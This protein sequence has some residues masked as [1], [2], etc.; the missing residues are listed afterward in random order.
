MS[1]R[2]SVWGSSVLTLERT[3]SSCARPVLDFRR[4]EGR[5]TD[6]AA[7]PTTL[8]KTLLT[9]R[10]MQTH[11]AFCREYDKQAMRIDASLAGTYPSRA[12]FYRWVSGELAGL[13][14]PDHCRVLEALF[15]GHS[16]SEL[17][18]VP[19][20]ERTTEEAVR[21]RAERPVD[22]RP[23][24]ERAFEESRVTID[25]AGFSGETLYG[26]IQEPVD[27]V[28]IGGL[29][30]KEISIRILVPDLS[31][32][33][34][35]PALVSTRGDD[36]AV[37]A[38]SEQIA[39]RSNQAILAAV[40]ELTDLGLV[41]AASAEVR[42]YRTAP[43]FKLYILN[44][45]EAF[46]GFY[47]VVEHAVSVAGTSTEIFDAMGKD[48]ALF[49]YESNDDSTS[50]GCQYVMQAQMWFDSVWETIAQDFRP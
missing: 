46:F 40:N 17:F 47:P 1:H 3:I 7:P 18:G 12:Q 48:A 11:R 14:Y 37:R 42:V 45:N 9:Q 10:H 35:L 21:G 23:Y 31:V 44:R 25:F 39:R 20:T 36:T 27:R 33:A 19:I 16:A 8:L 49:H 22:L 15:P 30:P 2:D 26:A 32:P 13:P 43:L 5:G 4:Q 6:V 50:L 38:R 34:G 28:R 29:A 24:I 41:K